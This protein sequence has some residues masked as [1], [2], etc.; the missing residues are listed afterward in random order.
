MLSKVK[1]LQ[2]YSLSGLDG[3]IGT[4]E[5]FLFDDRHWTIRYVV[6]KTGKWLS[7]RKVLISPYALSFTSHD[8]KLLSIDL[9]KKQ[10]ED[11]PGLESHQPVS[12]QFEISYHSYFGWPIYW[13]GPYVWG[14][15]PYLLLQAGRKF[16]AAL[17]P[18]AEQDPDLR[19][20]DDMT[21]IVVKGK[22]GEIGHVKDFIV[23]EGPWTI[24]YLIVDT[25]MWWP[26]KKILLSP[27]WIER[28]DQVTREIIVDLSM[29]AIR[30]APDFVEAPLVSREYE[31]RLHRHYS[32]PEYWMEAERNFQKTI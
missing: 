6:A 3:P 2:G 4:V 20:I 12:R 5:G 32:R 10:I 16:I 9:S 23:D 17:D 28:F 24:R 27:K 7:G 21:G 25:G 22:D 18:E 29:Q 13:D 15:F 26:G 14:A 8:N 1:T 30:S 11:S 31:S 19:S